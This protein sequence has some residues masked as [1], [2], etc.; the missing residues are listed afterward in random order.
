VLSSV[1]DFLP[2]LSLDLDFLL[3]L[4]LAYLTR[5]SSSDFET[6]I[7]FRMPSSYSLEG[8]LVEKVNICE[9]TPG[10]MSLT[11]AVLFLSPSS[12]LIL[13]RLR[14]IVE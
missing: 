11:W 10:F 2:D 12:L 3:G 9:R 7:S 5:Q 1:E 13:L 8:S 14:L 6:L 4:K